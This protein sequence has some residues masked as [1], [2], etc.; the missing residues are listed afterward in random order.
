ME[1]LKITDTE[2]TWEVTKQKF[3][4]KI[5]YE[6]SIINHGDHISVT[7]SMTVNGENRQLD[8]VHIP[9]ELIDEIKKIPQ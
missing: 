9:I 5:K 3:G 1:N 4:S 8:M 7:K 2:I 6:N